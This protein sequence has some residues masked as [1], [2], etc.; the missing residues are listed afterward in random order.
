MKKYGV[1]LI[2]VC[3]IF[4]V[5]CVSDSYFKPINKTDDDASSEDDLMKEIQE[6]E[7]SSG[8]SF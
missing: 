7:K 4:I 3:L 6:I 1:I 8:R 5:G 2:L